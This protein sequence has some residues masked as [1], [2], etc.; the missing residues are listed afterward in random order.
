MFA[1][2]VAG[3]WLLDKVRNVAAQHYGFSSSEE[4]Y[5][6]SATFRQFIS[7]NTQIFTDNFGLSSEQFFESAN[8]F[9]L[10]NGH[11]SITALLVDADPTLLDS[12]RTSASLTPLQIRNVVEKIESKIK[13]EPGIYSPSVSIPMYSL[14]TG[15]YHYGQST[16]QLEYIMEGAN[17]NLQFSASIISN[18]VAGTVLGSTRVT[19][20][21]SVSMTLDI[22]SDSTSGVV[23]SVHASIDFG[24]SAFVR[25]DI[26]EFANVH[27]GIKA[28]VGKSLFL[29]ATNGT[30][31]S[32]SDPFTI[33]I[34]EQSKA[35]V[36]FDIAGHQIGKI[37]SVA[38]SNLTTPF[39]FANDL[40]INLSGPWQTQLTV[41]PLDGSLALSESSKF[42]VGQAPPSENTRAVPSGITTMTN[43]LS[44]FGTVIV[45]GKIEA[46]FVGTIGPN[47]L[48][49]TGISGDTEITQS[50]PT[51]ELAKL[52]ATS[53]QGITLTTTGDGD[54]F[55]IQSTSSALGINSE[56]SRPSS[57]I[58]LV[59]IGPSGEPVDVQPPEPPKP[60]VNECVPTTLSSPLVLYNCNNPTSGSDYRTDC[61]T[62]STLSP[63]QLNSANVFSCTSTYNCGDSSGQYACT[64]SPD[65]VA[66]VADFCDSDPNGHPIDSNCKVSSSDPFLCYTN[67]LDNIYRRCVFGPVYLYGCGSKP[68]DNIDYG[69][70][71]CSLGYAPGKRYSCF[72]S[73]D[74]STI[75]SCTDPGE[76]PVQLGGFNCIL[77][78]A[79]MGYTCTGF[80]Y[81]AIC[82]KF[83]PDNNWI[84]CQEVKY[85]KAYYSCSRKP[86]NG[87]NPVTSVP[88]VCY[89]SEQGTVNTYECYCTSSGT[90][91]ACSEA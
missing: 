58:V 35:L 19:G 71:D 9:A 73:S 53:I 77:I 24:G 8:R 36:A 79:G 63:T 39:L 82:F 4:H 90:V 12:V 32:V 25:L 42:V 28:P 38:V 65:N 22:V 74:K 50:G 89:E 14:A 26:D 20:S 11:E 45:G 87:E 30:S 61:V 69:S 88:P 62:A 41:S 86:K 83:P 37:Q 56:F 3:N 43:N 44:F 21:D 57:L 59:F 27:F 40:L 66:G 55:S 15:V 31:I 84:H 23:E 64:L 81:N 70:S 2:P 1:V 60:I 68:N 54:F 85:P 34:D 17:P 48:I 52:I 67:P 29:T 51:T 13:S 75:K 91:W 6:S 47:S 49:I 18:Q 7:S 78:P 33:N 76:A 46:K 5:V 72:L 16:T 10:A 80:G